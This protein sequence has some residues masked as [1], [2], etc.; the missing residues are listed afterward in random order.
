MALIT[1]KAQDAF[2]A[3]IRDLANA[4]ADPTEEA[5][6][7]PARVVL[8]SGPVTDFD[9]ISEKELGTTTVSSITNPVTAGNNARRIRV[10]TNQGDITIADGQEKQASHYALIVETARGA[11]GGADEILATNTLSTPATVADGNNFTLNQ[12]DITIA[13]PA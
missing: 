12:F 9:N 4:V 3:K 6:F 10:D 7:S 8:L 1:E 2:L 11:R 5:D 13:Q